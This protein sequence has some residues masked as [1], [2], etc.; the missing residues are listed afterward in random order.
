MPTEISCITWTEIL[1]LGNHFKE[2]LLNNVVHPVAPHDG[3]G[4]YTYV[5]TNNQLTVNGTGCSHW[6]TNEVVNGGEISTEF[7]FHLL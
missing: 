3:L 4:S 5:Y 1:E 2:L 7:L 6:V